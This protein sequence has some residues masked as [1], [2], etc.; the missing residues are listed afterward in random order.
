MPPENMLSEMEAVV[1]RK[2]L[3]VLIEHHYP[4][5]G[6]KSGL[7]PYSLATMRRVAGIDM[8][9]ERI[10]GETTILSFLQRLKNKK[11]SPGEQ[12]LEMVKTQRNELGM[13]ME[14]AASPDRVH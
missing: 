8:L 10:P 12:I 3:I 9:S 5:D 14:Q 13:P 6:I 4:M 11:H 1:S 7:P 2:A